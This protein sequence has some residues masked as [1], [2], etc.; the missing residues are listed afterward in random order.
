[1]HSFSLTQAFVFGLLATGPLAAGFSLGGDVQD[2]EKR[3]VGSLASIASK[4]VREVIPEIARRHHTEAQIA[5]KEASAA[6]KHQRR[7][8]PDEFGPWDSEE[9]EFGSWVDKRSPSPHH[10]EAQIAAKEAAAA[11]KH[12]R[13]DPHHTEAQIAAKE[14]AAA[15]KHQRRQAPDEFGPWDSEEDEFGS[16]VDKRSP[17]HTEAQIA[18]KE[19]AAAKKHQRRDPHHTEA[20]IAAKEAATA[21]KNHKRDPQAPDEFGP[22]DSEEDEFGSWVDKRSP[23]PSPHHT[24]AQIAAKEA[25]AAKKNHKRGPHHTEAQ[26][27]A[28]EAAAAK[29]NHKRDPQAPD[30]FGPWDSEEDEFGSWVDKRSPSPSPHHTEAQIAA[31]EAAAAKKHQRLGRDPHHTEAQIAAK[32]AAAAKKGHGN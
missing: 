30:E 16:W 31:K 21:K 18:A 29:K 13:R 7:Q 20:Q 2:V 3:H 24:E 22:W 12:Q 5:A 17:H 1:M 14:A 23:S 6:K 8:A 25:A 4:V 27:A 10:T 11:K 19:A 26:I 28:K 32:E 9:D 15:K